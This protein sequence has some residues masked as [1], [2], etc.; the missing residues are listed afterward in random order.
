VET[1]KQQTGAAHGYLVARAVGA[2][3]AYGL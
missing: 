2:V 3:L 1:I